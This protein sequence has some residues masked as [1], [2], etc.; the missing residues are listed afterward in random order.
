MLS[1][2]AFKTESL[3]VEEAA[4]EALKEISKLSAD[5]GIPSGLIELGVK[6]E[7]L[8]KLAENALKDACG[9]T[10]PRVATHED[11]VGIF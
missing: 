2:W 7:H 8:D 11:I 4:N 6:E 5:I 3:S 10:N 1:L 9:L